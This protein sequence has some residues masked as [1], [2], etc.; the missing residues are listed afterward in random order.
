MVRTNDY[1]TIAEL[2]KQLGVSV[3]TVRNYVEAGKIKPEMIVGS[4][5]YFSKDSVSKYWG[6][7]TSRKRS[8]SEN[9]KYAAVLYISNEVNE[10]IPRDRIDLAMKKLGVVP[11]GE[12]TSNNTIQQEEMNDFLKYCD[13]NGFY[14]TLNKDIQTA[15]ERA[16]KRIEKNVL[17]EL[18]KKLSELDS[19]PM[20]IEAKKLLKSDCA[21]REEKAD[22]EKV[23]QDFKK[24]EA[25]LTER[26]EAE[27]RVET[28]KMRVSY[29][30]EHVD[31]FGNISAD[32]PEGSG[33]LYKKHFEKVW[34]KFV[35]D[36]RVMKNLTQNHY[37]SFMIQVAD[38]DTYE[39][40]FSNIINKVYDEVFI[41]NKDK[42]SRDWQGMLS[43][44]SK[45]GVVF[46]IL[47]I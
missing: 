21:S 42:L 24:K 19:D 16:E 35:T 30:S 44:L 45:S 6:I 1:L 31:E 4:H 2:A 12:Q 26:I 17:T 10:S 18:E 39:I 36:Y 47:E 34:E 9:G 8:G 20:H 46:R 41:I 38:A 14:D 23:V 33:V 37:I 43:I 11:F 27:G 28:Q 25:E 32:A 40:P 3:P 13:N 22:A 5:Q 7:V 29:L 15:I